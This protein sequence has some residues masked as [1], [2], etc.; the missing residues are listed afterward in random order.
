MDLTLSLDG[1]STIISFQWE[2]LLLGQDAR[3]L[4]LCKKTA[5]SED[6]PVIY[7]HV[8]EVPICGPVTI[9]VGE[10]ASLCGP[11]KHHLVHQYSHGGHGETRKRIIDYLRDRPEKG[12]SE[13]LVLSQP[14]FDLRNTRLRKFIQNTLITWYFWEHEALRATTASLPEFLNEPR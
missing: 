8:L 14:A 2:P 5:S 9:Y 6:Q 1:H 7:R 4:W 10:G 13:I 12:W 11:L 3:Y